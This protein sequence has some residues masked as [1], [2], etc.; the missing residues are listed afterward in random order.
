MWRTEAPARPPA[1]KLVRALS[2]MRRRV[3]WASAW[4]GRAMDGGSEPPN[5]HGRK[6]LA[7]GRLIDY[8]SLMRAS[9]VAAPADR[10]SD[11]PGP[12]APSTSGASPAGGHRA[13]PAV[14]RW[15]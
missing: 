6:P 3:A 7:I 8:G 9:L 15:L 14:N 11:P 2:R 4:T 1:A 12:A 13:L 5:D 10:R